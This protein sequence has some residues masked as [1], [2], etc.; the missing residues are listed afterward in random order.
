MILR[1]TVHSQSAKCSSFTKRISCALSL[2][3][4]LL[5]L[6]NGLQIHAQAIGGG[7]IQGTVNDP[8]GSAVPG[9]TVEAVQKDSGTRR[10]VTSGSDGGYNLPSLPV[11]PYT[12]TVTKEGFSVYSQAGIV[13]QVGN[14]LSIPVTLQVGG[15]TQTVQ[16]DTQAPMVQKEDQSLSQVIDHQR[17]I[18]MP[19]NGRLATQLILLTAGTT[20]APN[21]DN[22]G[23]KN[24]PSSVSYSIAGS[25]GTSTNYLMDGTDNNDALTNVNLPFPFPDAIQEFSVQTSGLSAQYG[26]HPGAVVNIVT[27]SGTNQFHGTVFDF[28]RNG[29][30]NADNFFS[31]TRDSLKRNQF[32]GV[33]GGPIKRDRLFFFFGYQ[34]T[35]TRQQSNN[36][37]YFVPTQ[38]ILNGDWSTFESAGCHTNGQAL[39]LTN[40]ATGQAFSGNQIPTTSYNASAVALLKYLPLSTDPCGKVVYGAPNPQ[41]EDQY[42]GRLDWTINQKQALYGRYFVTHFTQPGFFG[43]NLL[44]AAVNPALN[45]QA[46]TVSIGHT[47]SLSSNLVNSFRLGGTRNFINRGAASDLINPNT[48]GIN[49]ASPVPNYIY[50]AVSGDFTSACGTCEAYSITTNAINVVDDLFWTRGKHHFAFGANYLYG[51]L[52]LQGTNN[53]NA[54]L[55]FNGSYTKDALADFMLGDLQTI[56]QGN[57]TGSTWRKNNVAGYVLDTYQ[58]SS[59]VT[60]NAGIRWESDLPEVETAGRGVSYSAAA[61]AAGTTSQIYKTAPAGL[62]FYGDQGIP[63]GYIQRHMDHFEP[64]VGVAWDPRGK[65]EESIRASYTLGFQ[66]PQIYLEDRFENNAPW[67]DAITLTNPVGGLSNPYSG[68]PGGNPFPQPFPPNPATAFFPT[69]GSYFVFPT[70]LKPSYTQT[71]NLSFQKQFAR[72]WVATVAYLGN[73]VL[74]IWAGNEENPSVYIPGRWTGSGS[75]GAL[76]VSPGT[77]SPC[78]ST[79][80]TAARR[81]LALQSPTKGA[82]FSEVSQEYDGGTSSYNGVFFTIEHRFANYFTLLSNYTYSHCLT[83]ATDVGDLGG[84]TFQNPANPLADYGN[85]GEDLRHNFNISI[86]TRSSV[87]GGDFVHRFLNGWQIAPIVTANSGLPFTPLTGTDVSLTAV[88]QDRPNLA[89]SPYLHGAGRTHWLNPASFQAAPTGSFGNTRPYSFFAPHYVDLDGAIMKYVPLHDQILLETRAE[90]FNCLNHPGLSAPNLT[91]SNPSTFGTI[92]STG[93]FMP[94]ILQLSLKIDF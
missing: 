40:P 55:T 77:G 91:L 17:V 62:L 13:I 74:H 61:F 59:K 50:L 54:Q 32:G 71:W 68:Y 31:T 75:C 90:C 64:R 69:Q 36:T 8:T 7:Q 39:A 16:V 6:A 33:I 24:Y 3:A 20:T 72:S 2:L 81:T 29:I 48:V 56:Y 84:N 86:V 93:N 15:V 46:Q 4:L 19:L 57:N 30:M 88:N 11:G 73:H 70:N 41:N 85:C 26:L 23:T 28:F 87:K 37:T 34:G 67:G 27:K 79:G 94:R 76:T 82:Y 10:V 89:G 49:I 44:Q 1:R 25:Q 78:S 80:N 9:A 60:L 5:S 21:G 51:H 18:D 12:L 65:G 14:N 63:K 83:S 43:G 38:A 35:R 92:T 53:A 22:V 66:T 47:W 58:A 42:I 52:N 45:D